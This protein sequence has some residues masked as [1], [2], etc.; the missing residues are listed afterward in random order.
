MH[1]HGA[2]AQS[3]TG[4]ITGHRPEAS[5]TTNHTPLIHKKKQTRNNLKHSRRAESGSLFA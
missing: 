4:Q 5:L 3:E 1:Q 2:E